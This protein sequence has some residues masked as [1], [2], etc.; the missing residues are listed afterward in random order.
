M[1]QGFS[2]ALMVAL[3][4]GS[5]LYAQSP[6]SSK[7]TREV[8]LLGDRSLFSEELLKLVA[9]YVKSAP[10]PKVVPAN[11]GETFNMG[12]ES[13]IRV[14]VVMQAGL[15]VAKT[16]EV[17]EPRPA[18]DAIRKK[19]GEPDKTTTDK[20]VPSALI[21]GKEPTVHWYGRLLVVLAREEKAEDQGK[22]YCIV[23]CPVCVP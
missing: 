1:R 6:A 20:E 12:N 9:E 7:A 11:A 16:F 22:V 21:P 23:Y 15:A 14:G 17:P 18:F 2:Q 19:Y 4:V 8:A 5:A 3:V 13:G 10:D